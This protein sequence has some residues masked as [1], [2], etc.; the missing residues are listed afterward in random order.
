MT[1]REAVDGA[2]Y[3]LPRRGQRPA[4]TRAEYHGWNATKE[5]LLFFVR[6][7]RGKRMGI[8]VMPDE[9]IKPV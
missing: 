3:D 5:F 7:D 4:Y 2:L 1:A 8:V 6:D 9:Q